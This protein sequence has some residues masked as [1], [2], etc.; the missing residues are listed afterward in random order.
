MMF[1]S[2]QNAACRLNNNFARLLLSN[3]C[4]AMLNRGSLA[5]WLNTDDKG[6]CKNWLLEQMRFKA[7]YTQT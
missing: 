4:Q 7:G 1:Y 2:V 6:F 3:K 5:D